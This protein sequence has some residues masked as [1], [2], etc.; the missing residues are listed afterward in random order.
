MLDTVEITNYFDRHASRYDELI[1]TVAFQLDDAYR[2]LAEYVSS[3]HPTRTGLRV[4]EL[5]IGTGKFTKYLL[6][7]N[8][9]AVVTGVDASAQMIEIARHNLIQYQERLSFTQGEFP[10][11]I[12]NM[13]FDCVV[14]A[15]ALSFYGIDYTKLFRRV[16]SVLDRGGVFAYAVNVAYNASSVDRVL[17]Q[18]LRR[19]ISVTAEQLLWLK[20]IGPNVQLYQVPAD[21]HRATLSLGGFSDVDCIYL[22]HKLGIFSGTK[23]QVAV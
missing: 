4:L 16:H 7:A 19:Q 22:R 13:T 23:P 17:S 5:G 14:S 12:P 11:S 20:G 21:W 10:D 9:T 6:Q 15:I 1:E 18:M 2:Y 3:V 8:P